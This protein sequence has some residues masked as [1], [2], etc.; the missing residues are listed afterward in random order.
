MWG[1]PKRVRPRVLAILAGL[2]PEVAV[3][4]LRSDDEVRRFVES[5]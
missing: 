4:H 1:Y 5:V 2:G 3:H